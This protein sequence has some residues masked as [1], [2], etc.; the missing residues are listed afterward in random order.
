MN[1]RKLFRKFLLGYPMAAALLIAFWVL[2]VTA[3]PT[4]CCTCDEIVHLMAGY[5]Y[6]KLNNYSVDPENGNLPQRLAALPLLLGDYRAPSV[7]EHPEWSQWV[8]G[9][10]FFYKLVRPTS[11]TGPPPRW[12][13]TPVRPAKQLAPPGPTGRSPRPCTPVQPSLSWS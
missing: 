10:E 2:V 7:A 12:T 1:E 6:W 4:K 11:P 3:V 5:S 8:L 9:Y 13:V